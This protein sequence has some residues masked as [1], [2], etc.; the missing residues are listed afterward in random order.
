MSHLQKNSDESDWVSISHWGLFKLPETR[1]A[2]D[3]KKAVFIGGSPYIKV[4]ERK[5]H[6][7][8]GTSPVK[9]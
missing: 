1:R 2:S 6:D 9:A 3:G 7:F 5:W 8:S 4:T